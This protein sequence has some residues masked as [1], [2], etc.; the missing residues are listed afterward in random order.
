MHSRSRPE[1]GGPAPAA[2]SR[3]AWIAIGDPAGALAV[4]Q[5]LSLAGWSILR[6]THTLAE[7]TQGL[8]EV[9]EPVDVV[10]S[11]LHFRDGDGLLLIR[12]L[13]RLPRPPALFLVSRQQRAV[14]KAAM[15]LADACGLQ[16]AGFAEQPIDPDRIAARMAGFQARR[17][18]GPRPAAPPLLERVELQAL[19]DLGTLVPWMQPKVRLSSHEVVGFEALMRAHD[20]TGALIMPDRLIS[21]L[22]AHQL[23]DEA[24]LS[25]A[26]QTV[27][28]VAR[29]LGEGMAVS[30]SI[31]VSM[32][33]LSKV[34]FCRR[35]V[36]VV[37]D[38]RL[39]PSWI[40]VEITETD[41][42]ADLVSVI[43]NT[44]RIRMLGFNLAIDDFGTGYSS[45]YQ[46]SSLPFS[47]LKIER[48]FIASAHQDPSRQA[49]V[50][51]CAQ[52]GLSLGLHVVAEG[53]E[54][55]EELAL[56]GHTGCSEVQGY[57]IAR[58]MPM[59]VALDWLR[60]L[61]D[62]QVPWPQPAQ[63]VLAGA[64][65]VA[66]VEAASSAGGAGTAAAGS[67]PIALT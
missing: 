55:V 64:T 66:G 19:L 41:A 11:G 4:A 57:L 44:A 50:R 23:L 56:A 20:P 10:V 18:R 3:S 65:D 34:E 15:A 35:L 31:N 6:T 60:A 62:M 22:S 21:A 38:A 59:A 49:I 32:S 33:S 45:L 46:L 28:F 5:A 54:T 67:S 61:D 12:A 43:E 48:A 17:A 53:V 37:E 7:T 13:A 30:A 14:I 1:A 24:T 47:E 39:D 52:L 16:L 58:P 36:E 40:T 8:A 25:M 51:A 63:G 2:A 26:R 29:C 27:A 42:M 9:A